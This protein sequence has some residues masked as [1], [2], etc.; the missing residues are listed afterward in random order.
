MKIKTIVFGIVAAL[1]CGT[2][3]AAN[4][5]LNPNFD[6]GIGN[7]SAFG[8]LGGFAQFDGTFGNPAGSVFLSASMP[9]SDAG[10]HQCIAISAPADVDFIVDGFTD[11]SSG[12]GSV[13]IVAGAYTS[14]DCVSGFISNLPQGTETF[15]PGGWNG[16][17]LSLLNQPLPAGTQ[18]VALLLQTQAGNGVQNYH[19]DNVRFGP[20]GTTP[21]RLQSFDVE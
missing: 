17:E 4:L 11:N 10:V 21:V 7:W 20:T 9:S 19:F 2:A 13:Q 16:F 18:S 12:S 6:S 1:S 14:T 3:G 5:V 15:P 8:N